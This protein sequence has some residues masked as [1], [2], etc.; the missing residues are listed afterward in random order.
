MARSG[1]RRRGGALSGVNA[2]RS[3]S[4]V[5]VPGRHAA[6]VMLAS[7][8]R[9]QP[10]SHP[11]REQEVAGDETQRHRAPLESDTLRGGAAGSGEEA[12]RRIA[13]GKQDE[14]KPENIQDPAGG[15]QADKAS[16]RASVILAGLGF[17]PKM[18][19]QATKE[20]SGGWRMRLALARALFA[21]PDLLLLDEPTNMLDVRAILWLENYLQ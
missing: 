16:A 4:V 18:Q 19:Q 14:Q 12:E 2:A 7:Q 5:M 3:G 6:E 10:T 11:P 9:S 17:S 15:D 8:N 20:F 1:V 21:R 13:S